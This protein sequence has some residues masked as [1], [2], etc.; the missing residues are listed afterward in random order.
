MSSKELAESE[1]EAR[2]ELELISKQDWETFNSI[3]SKLIVW[4]TAAE[5][6]TQE[7]RPYYEDSFLDAADTLRLHL[8]YMTNL[9]GTPFRPR[10]DPAM[11]FGE[12]N[13]KHEA[14][15]QPKEK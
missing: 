13:E 11:K 10:V 15:P 8:L 7:S 14:T 5:L 2:R 4:L 3:L 9:D 12:Q 6:V 1:D